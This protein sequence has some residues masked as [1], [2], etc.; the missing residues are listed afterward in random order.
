VT[1]ATVAVLMFGAVLVGF[2]IAGE[3]RAG[4]VLCGVLLGFFLA[5][6]AMAHIVATGAQRLFEWMETWHT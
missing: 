4:Q 3:L 5:D 2:W 1:L 6:S